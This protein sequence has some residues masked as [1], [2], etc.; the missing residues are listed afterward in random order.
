MPLNGGQLHLPLKKLTYWQKQLISFHYLQAKE[1][2][3]EA[4]QA[5]VKESERISQLHG[6]SA[7]S[8][9]RVAPDP[10]ELTTADKSEKKPSR[11]QRKMRGARHS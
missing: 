5:A 10:R 9:E 6:I 7:A 2:D 8:I 4:E 11:R 1:R 3:Q